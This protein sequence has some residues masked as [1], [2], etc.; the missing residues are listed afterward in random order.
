MS[1]VSVAAARNGARLS[2][3]LLAIAKL[4]EILDRGNYD[5]AYARVLALTKAVDCNELTP[6]YESWVNQIRSLPPFCG[7]SL[8]EESMVYWIMCRVVDYNNSLPFYE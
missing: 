6:G 3:M 8:A 1:K 5:D 2:I 7:L 4:Q